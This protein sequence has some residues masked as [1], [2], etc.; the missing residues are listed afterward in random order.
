M[1]TGSPRALLRAA[2]NPTD[3]RDE[4]FP[5]DGAWGLSGALS[6]LINFSSL[7]ENR[8]SEGWRGGGYRGGLRREGRV[9]KKE[10][11]SGSWSCLARKKARKRWAKTAGM[12]I[13]RRGTN[14]E[15][16]TAANRS[17]RE[18]GRKVSPVLNRCT[19]IIATPQ[20]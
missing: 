18:R 6:S 3:R 17:G 5:L 2:R 19:A 7:R 16:E 11:R 9:R 15:R 12:R 4:R 8:E 14:T 20:Y 10:G 1:A 13:N